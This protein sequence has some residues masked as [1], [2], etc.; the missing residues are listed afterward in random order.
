MASVKSFTFSCPKCDKV[1]RTGNRP[2]EGKK[3]KCPA[4]GKPF[5]PELDDDDD[6]GSRI[7]TKPSLKAKQKAKTNVSK[8]GVKKRRADEED[9]DD[10]R[11]SAKKKA[12]KKSGGNMILIILLV[13]FGGG[14]LVSAGL[15]GVGAFVWPGFLKSEKTAEQKLAE[16][17]KKDLEDAAKKI[18]DAKPAVDP[19]KDKENK[20]KK[21]KVD[22]AEDK[23]KKKDGDAKKDKDGA[24]AK[25]GDKKNQ[26]AKLV[27][28]NNI[29]DFILPE[30]PILVGANF[31]SLRAS[32]QF[33]P[34]MNKIEENIPAEEL[35]KLKEFRELL[36]STDQILVSVVIGQD[37]PKFVIGATTTG[38]QS[39]KTF[40]KQ[41]RPEEKLADRFPIHRSAEDKD[42]KLTLAFPGDKLVLIT[43]LKDDDLTTL[44]ETA[45]QKK[46]VP[47]PADGLRKSVDKAHLWGA[48]VFDD[49]IRDKF[50]APKE[51]T[52]DVP[53]AAQA[54]RA[55][56]QAKGASFAF[57]FTTTTSGELD[58]HVDCD[59]PAAAKSLND[60][61]V[62]MVNFALKKLQEDK[63]APPSFLRDFKSVKITTKGTMVSLF[64][65][66]NLE[67]I[68]D[69]AAG[70]PRKD[71]SKDLAK[72]DGTPP[73]KDVVIVVDAT[74][75]VQEFRANG[76][77][78]NQK[79][80]DK[81]IEVSGKALVAVPSYVIIEGG[82][83][84]GGKK[85]AMCV[86]GYFEK[87]NA[88]EKLQAGQ[89]VTIRGRFSGVIGHILLKNCDLVNV[90][91]LA[92]DGP[93]P[94]PKDF[95][96]P[97]P[98]DLAKKDAAPKDGKKDAAAKDVAIKD[99]P[100]KDGAPKFQP[101]QVVD[102]KLLTLQPNGQQ[103]LNM[104]LQQGQG[105]VFYIGSK[106]Q[107]KLVGKKFD[108]TQPHVKVEV[109]QAGAGGNKIL[110]Q[111]TDRG[112]G[113][114]FEFIAPASDAYRVR[115]HNLA[116]AHV[117][118]VQIIVRAK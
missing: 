62:A 57:R 74:A 20:D 29:N 60:G 15:C 31:S 36:R 113:A 80:Q 42:P 96:P 107:P 69:L 34:I 13:L 40:K 45:A 71:S 114:Q 88:G 23:D 26:P 3:I 30:A 44:L 89:Y 4:C 103:E 77:A 70:P 68:Q 56:R 43:N 16:A 25:D 52:D 22:V 97:P 61:A 64:V 66:G 86:Q 38:T 102:Q 33:D 2:A 111:G 49:M 78:A 1:L 91:Q 104:K 35:A 50:D 39:L 17:L 55:L 101:G 48:Y 116:A 110:A 67:T 115:I 54:A 82:E 81:W 46:V 47:G 19:N 99:A 8:T 73:P 87:A 94:P 84:A 9:D 6:E 58:F 32:F 93:P 63:Q 83:Q 53:E 98:K 76:N 109:H 41:L 10:E 28:N 51:V 72:K 24:A 7:Q 11:P 79:Y 117:V 5:V 92:K 12:A 14:F 65:R 37:G 59:S 106:N 75:L 90:P 21:D 27:N 100:V 108:I 112:T 18:E 85:I 105:L 95:P 118:V